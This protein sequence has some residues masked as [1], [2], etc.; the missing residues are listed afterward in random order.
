MRRIVNISVIIL[1]IAISLS[2]CD[3]CVIRSMD[4]AEIMM[5]EDPKSAL[6]TLLTIDRS[7][8][9]NKKQLARY[10]L[11][12]SI[13]YDKNYV[14]LKSDTIIAPA[15]FYYKR[16]GKIEDKI[17]TFYYRG[18]IEMN[19]MNYDQAMSYFL[20][21]EELIDSSNDY[22]LA[23]L[24]YSA[25][26]Y[27]YLYSYDFERSYDNEFKAAQSFNMVNDTTRYLRSLF[28]MLHISNSSQDTT[29]IRHTVSLIRS[30]SSILSSKQQEALK[31]SNLYYKILSNSQVQESLNTYLCEIDNRTIVN[32]QI[33]AYA[34]LILGEYQKSYE[35]LNLYYKSGQPISRTT[36]WIKANLYEKIGHK[37]E[38]IEAYKAYFELTETHIRGM[39]SSE[40]KFI[41]ERY[42]AEI[43]IIEKKNSITVLMLISIILLLLCIC[44]CYIYRQSYK[45]RL[46][47]RAIAIQEKM[48]L[49][50]S[51]DKLCAEKKEI[52]ETLA[53]A[54]FE[55]KELKRIKRNTVLSKCVRKQ[56][57]ERLAVLN[58]FVEAMIS[59]NARVEAESMF[60]QLTEDRDYFLNS[61]K[62]SFMIAHTRFI[63]Y[64]KMAK[65]S[66]REIEY[67]CLFAV[68]F[69][70]S[71]IASYMGYQNRHS[72]YNIC[73]NIRKRLNIPEDK[74][75]DKFIKNKALELDK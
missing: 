73:L 64:L 35:A 44:L 61:T 27:I 15:V 53:K 48:S 22:T 24:V 32:W 30:N 51:R 25:K 54:E 49:E 62:L 40:T 41:E 39:Y 19:K 66:D 47:E 72:F 42:N 45:L 70:G 26:S 59:S 21:A 68:G 20:Q 4:V 13:A 9:H 31:S 63:E 29:K 56:V 57:D 5:D 52:E 74:N 75:I 36:Y 33:V 50:E 43:E 69:N 17:K 46:L 7:K 14:D 34:Y 1:F 18:R 2:S 37:E 12:L 58:K 28:N 10:S 16:Y 38:A 11:L 55:I 60:R 65:L 3:T 71:Q 67:C 6:D 23:G 8:L